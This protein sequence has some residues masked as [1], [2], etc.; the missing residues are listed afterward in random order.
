MAGYSDTPLFQKLGLQESMRV[1]FTHMPKEL[2]PVFES[3]PGERHARFTGEFDYVHLFTITEKELVSEFATA[4]KFLKANGMVWIS[5][6]KAGKLGT[7]LN[8]NMIRKIGLELGL[9]D[10]KVAALDETWSGLKF[11]YRLKDR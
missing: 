6:P 1:I 10:V 11:V 3:A 7:N 4:K 2:S 8:E 9:V 5:W